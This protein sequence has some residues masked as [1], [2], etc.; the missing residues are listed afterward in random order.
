MANRFNNIRTILFLTYT[1]IIVVVFTVL[2]LW[3]YSWAS[4]EL[5]RNALDTLAGMGTSVQDQIDSEIQKMNDVS[6]NVMYSNLVKDQFKRL[7]EGESDEDA[8]GGSGSSPTLPEGPIIP[9]QRESAKQLADILTAAI[10]PS[11]P[12]EQLYL[13]DFAGKMYGNGFD[14]GERTYDPASKAW[15]EG[16]V[17]NPSMK[18]IGKPVI[19]SEMA[20]FVSSREGQ[21]SI[22]LFRVF[23]DNYNVPIGIVEIKQ[24][25]SRIFRSI[26]DQRKLGAYREK[27]IVY[28]KQGQIVFPVGE[29]STDYEPYIR[30]TVR[31]GENDVSA[32]A[33]ATV[34]NPASGEDELLSVH[35][36]E[37][38]GWTTV[39]IV[40]ER[41]LLSPLS[42]FSKKT[43]LVA[44]VI[45]L[46]AIVLSFAAARRIASPIQKIH[47]AVRNY[48]LEDAGTGRIASRELNS[49][50]NELDQLHWEFQRMSARVKESMDDLLLAQ[51]QELQSRLVALQSQMNPHF[52]YNTLATIQVMAEENM[53]E[54]IVSLSENMSGFLRY[55][56][57]D[58]SLVTM[59]TELQH[60][61][62][63]L[64]I[65]QIRFGSKLAFSFAVDERITQDQ[66]PKLVIQPLVENA[67][68]FVTRTQPDWLIQVVGRLEGDRWIIEVTDNGAGFSEE[69]LQTLADKRR[70]MERMGEIP[71]L[72]LNGMGLLNIYIRLRLT[73]GDSALFQVNNLPSGG[74]SIVIGGRTANGG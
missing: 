65:N 63:Y 43:V 35:Y 70:E 37:L 69:S 24:Y 19:D 33:S 67:I 11:R 62:N 54:Q 21:Y 27:V 50:L 47:R 57:S 20:K 9:S 12:V 68:K 41:E 18:H 36:S 42:A 48:Q 40:S 4:G 74:A 60:T 8:Q 13:Y 45:L 16:V 5:R 23:F 39:L 30:L 32:A 28:D 31:Q 1:L 25:Y 71:M 14:N 7:V 51:S 10:G 52:L 61:R 56:S 73:Y 53:N 58:A 55:I 38:T 3:F 26:L 15:Y 34:R 66:I 2:V 59:E 17:Q 46:M 6:L 29:D 49:G 64:E 44:F 72:Q 22:S